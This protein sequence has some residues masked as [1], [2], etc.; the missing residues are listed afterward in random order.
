MPLS[1]NPVE[2]ASTLLPRYPGELKLYLF[3]RRGLEKSFTLIHACFTGFWLG[4]L[5]KQTLQSIDQYYYDNEK[6]YYSEAYN[7]R[8]LWAWEK[9]AISQYFHACKSLMVIGAGGGREVLALSKMGFQ[10]DGFECNTQLLEFANTLIQKDASTARMEFLDR[11][12]CPNNGKIYDGAIMGWGSYMLIQ[13]QAKRLAFLQQLKTQLP[14]N[15]P[16]LISFYAA[17]RKGRYYKVVMQVGNVFRSLLG[18]DR[19][20]LGD[21]LAPEYVHYFTRKDID[22]EFKAAGFELKLYGTKSY[23][24]AVGLVLESAA[25]PAAIAPPV[26]T[27]TAS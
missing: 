12:Q 16:L 8:G 5:S 1:P 9:E 21:D 15:A 11:D 10:A 22:A 6:M 26:P 4:V 2:P 20:E 13:T 19:L 27:L 24:Y 23:G 17:P 18:R 3:L 25:T 7:R 14:A